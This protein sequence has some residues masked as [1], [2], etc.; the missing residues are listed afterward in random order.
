MARYPL[1]PGEVE[2]L[3]HMA[4][5]LTA[6]GIA[7]Q[8]DNSRHTIKRRKLMIYR[9]LG[10]RNGAEAITVAMQEGYLP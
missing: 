1:T 9:K 8:L 2:L 10:V 3:R 6:A 4:R 7:H 5:G